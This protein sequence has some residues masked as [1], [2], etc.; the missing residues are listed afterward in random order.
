MDNVTIRRE[1]DA[2]IP[3]I[4]ELTQASF[5]G[6]AEAQ[7]VEKLR[8][9]DALAVSLVAVAV[10]EIVGHV[11]VSPIR[12]DDGTG[13]WFV[14]APIAVTPEQRGQ[15]IGSALT[16]HALEQLKEGGAGGVTIFNAPAGSEH[17]GFDNVP[18]LFHDRPLLAQRL[19]DSQF[20][21]GRVF[22]HGAF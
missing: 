6:S 17:F 20:P 1:T 19:N 15:G 12:I 18:E 4:T 8:D 22:L 11:A 21:A 9:D 16:Q 10:S 13:G 7:I 3:A 5:G 14:I 2:D